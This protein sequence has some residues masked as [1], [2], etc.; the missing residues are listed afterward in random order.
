MCVSVYECVHTGFLREAQ[1]LW[2]EALQQ[3]PY[4]SYLSPPPPPTPDSWMCFINNRGVGIST[5]NRM[6]GFMVLGGAADAEL[7]GMQSQSSASG[8]LT[9]GLQSPA[10][11]ILSW[12]TWGKLLNL[13]APQATLSVKWGQ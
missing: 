9:G 1:S 6:N 10:P 7:E 8:S 12:V 4:F 2:E 5:W 13:S 11:P 3:I